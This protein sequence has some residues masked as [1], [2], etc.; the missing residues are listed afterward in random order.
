MSPFWDHLGTR[1]R[2]KAI[3]FSGN[4]VLR[5]RGSFL[6]AGRRQ[7]LL[8]EWRNNTFWATSVRL[9]LRERGRLGGRHSDILGFCESWRS[10]KILKKRKQN[11]RAWVHFFAGPYWRRS[12]QV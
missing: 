9:V 6:A 1:G 7:L 12:S 4:R 10:K 3:L 8:G 2:E 11:R 5:R